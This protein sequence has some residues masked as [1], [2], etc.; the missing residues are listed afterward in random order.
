MIA[1]SA[2]KML[3]DRF[4]KGTAGAR[5]TIA[6]PLLLSVIASLL[7]FPS[8]GDQA[9]ARLVWI[10]LL[11]GSLMSLLLWITLRSHQHY[12]RELEAQH[13][14]LQKSHDDFSAL[15]ASIPGTVIRC[16]TA[17]SW[18]VLYMNGERDIST[19]QPVNRFLSG[20][21]TYRELVHPDDMPRIDRAVRRASAADHAYE[22]EYRV[23][24]V[25][26]N[27]RWASLN[28][29][30][31]YDAQGR[32]E[33]FE[34]VI[35]DT[36][37]RHLAQQELRELTEHLPVAIYH[38]QLKEDGTPRLIYISD[39]VERI[40]G[41]PAAEMIASSANIY[42]IVHPEDREAFIEADR[43]TSQ[44][45]LNFSQQVRVIPPDGRIRWLHVKSS[46]YRL[47][48]G[49]VTYHGIIEDITAHKQTEERSL[50][51]ESTLRQIF[52]TSN[53]GIFLVN[54]EG[55]IT[56]ANRRM[57]E[58]FHCPHE[59]LIGS[60][61][62]AHIHPDD[63]EAGQQKML[64]LIAS[65]IDSVDLERLY[66]REDGSQ[67]WGNLC[68]RR[69]KNADGTTAGLLGLIMDVTDRHQAEEEIRTLAFYDPLTQLPNRRLLLDRLQQGMTASARSQLHGALIF[70]DLDNFKSL[71]DTLGHDVGD[72][73]LVS[74]ARRLQTCVREG[75]TVARLGG[76]EFI[77]MLTEIHGTTND[78]IS[79]AET[80]G[81]KIISALNKPYSIGTHELRSTPSLGIALFLGHD[82][83]VD[84]MLKRADMAMYQA[85]AVGRNT[86]RFFDPQMQA[87]VNARA[88]MEAEL[89]RA[90]EQQEFMLFYQPQINATGDCTGVEALLRWQPTAQSM[91]SPAQF[92]PIAEETGQIIAIGGWVVLEA[93]R[94]QAIWQKNPETR[95]L[96]VAINISAKQ[97]QH[98]SFVHDL[99]EAIQQT[100]ADPKHIKLEL[101]ESILLADIREA[102][103]KMATLGGL[104][105]SFSV[106]DFGTGYSSLSYLKLLPL[107]QI[108][109]DQSFVRDI[110]N[111][112]NDRAICQAIIALGKALGLSVI[113]EGVESSPQWKM[114]LSDGCSEAQGYLF[115]MPL[116]A[117]EF[118]TWL[119]TKNLHMAQISAIHYDR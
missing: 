17:P 56:L 1:I 111:D 68:G 50:Q 52:D 5:L 7:L 104:G 25:D 2:A 91:I 92:I 24:H 88:H 65:E 83:S 43:K 72:Q 95:H 109:I 90:I 96:N 22:L 57:S 38:Y 107:Q 12:R 55:I 77:V 18:Q 117:K 48:D 15:I 36:T 110:L 78:S 119:N 49:Q 74:V 84:E 13:A 93:C 106:D 19:G 76:D 29:R 37:E 6:T 45:L 108:K 69:F 62:V 51:S 112:P 41:I 54:K 73:L 80:I 4:S 85:K 75:D 28:G 59:Q 47:A 114:L 39:N 11:C 66:W 94:Q 61:Y 71:N 89:Y 9:E 53:A 3:F 10:V 115:A 87:R 67:F 102:T 21:L 46:P 79:I 97:F 99:H 70:I 33:Q 100:G 14:E 82:T 8:Q 58:L 118:T 44:H 113:A 26:G 101:T 20:E 32:P 86:L 34:G 27:W 81:H 98:S 63:R 42:D 116:P 105:I 60:K 31:E 35:F 103:Q 30:F 23:L 16:K 40:M 64:D